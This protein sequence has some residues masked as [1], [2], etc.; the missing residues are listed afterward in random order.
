[1]TKQIPLS[2]GLFATVDDADFEWLS[3]WKW[4]ASRQGKKDCAN[5][6]FRAFRMEWLEGGKQRGVLMHRAIMSPN[7]GEVVDHLNGNPLDNR[8]INLRVCTQ[9]ENALN[10]VGNHKKTASTHKGV[11]WHKGGQKW[12][13]SFRGKYLG[14]FQTERAAAKAYNAAAI[15]HG[16][17]IP[18]NHVSGS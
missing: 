8:R 13:A 6:K 5:P 17:E 3:Q 7:E 14:L 12:M 11:H 1:M 18:L 16:G 10:R 15:A 2:R 9:A 4:S